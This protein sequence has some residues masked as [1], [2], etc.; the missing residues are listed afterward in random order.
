VCGSHWVFCI[1][2][3]WTSGPKGLKKFFKVISSWELCPSVLLRGEGQPLK[4]GL[5]SCPERS[6]RNYRYSLRNNAEERSSHLTSLQKPEVTHNFKLST[7]DTEILLICII[8]WSVRPSVLL[9]KSCYVIIP[10]DN[11]VRDGGLLTTPVLLFFQIENLVAWV[12]L[13]RTQRRPRLVSRLGYLLFWLRRFV[14]LP[15]PSQ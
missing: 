1:L 2:F 4:M 15:C 10:I 14:D 9:F 5:M 7:A 8:I 11:F 13:L 6:G 12:A 3:K